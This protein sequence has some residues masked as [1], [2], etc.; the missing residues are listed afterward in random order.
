MAYRNYKEKSFS[1]FYD[2]NV[3][4]GAVGF[5]G[6]DREIGVNYS[7]IICTI[8]ITRAFTSGGGPLIQFGTAT[9]FVSGA[10]FPVGSVTGTVVDLGIV[11][12]ITVQAEFGITIGG[13]AVTD[14]AGIFYMNYL[15]LEGAD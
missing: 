2:F 5:I 3:N 13:A 12:R 8:H 4:G 1:A 6:L 14:G 15:Q 7:P 10:V 11:G 9:E